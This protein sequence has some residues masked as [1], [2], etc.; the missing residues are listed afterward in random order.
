MVGIGFPGIF[1]KVLPQGSELQPVSSKY[2]ERLGEKAV[3]DFHLY[4]PFEKMGN[5][6]KNSKRP[7]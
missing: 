7:Q 5:K 2:H 3:S 4:F 6:T 1:K